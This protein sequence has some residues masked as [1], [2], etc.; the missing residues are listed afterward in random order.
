MV[1]SPGK[2]AMLADMTGVGQSGMDMLTAQALSLASQLPQCLMVYINFVLA[3]NPCGSWLASDEARLVDEDPCLGYTCGEL[4]RSQKV[5][6][7]KSA[8]I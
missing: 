8:V 7:N 5:R 4:H 3:E 2:R 1:G 6:T